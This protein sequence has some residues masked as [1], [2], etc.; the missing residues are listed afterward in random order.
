MSNFSARRITRSAGAAAFILTV[1][2]AGN[3][4]ADSQSVASSSPSGGVALGGSSSSSKSVSGTAHRTAGKRTAVQVS[5]GSG[6]RYPGDS[7]HLGDRILREGMSGHDV[8]V[9]QDYLTLAGFPTPVDGHFG[10]T[11]KQ[12]VISFE[13]AHGLTAD[14]VVT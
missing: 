3:A 12:N 14:G 4:L 13:K 6:H 10:P 7:Q 2:L 1:S 11:T 9:L 5:D 8:R